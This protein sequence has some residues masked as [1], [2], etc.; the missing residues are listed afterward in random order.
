MIQRKIKSDKKKVHKIC[1]TYALGIFE[2]EFNMGELIKITEYIPNGI[3]VNYLSSDEF[4]IVFTRISNGLV[5][6]NDYEKAIAKCRLTDIM[7]LI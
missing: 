3:T 6:N 7:K 1:V 5:F 4:M 2:F